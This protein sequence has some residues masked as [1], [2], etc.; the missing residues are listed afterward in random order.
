MLLGEC[1]RKALH[2][3]HFPHPRHDRALN[4]LQPLVSLPTL[5]N[6]R[7]IKHEIERE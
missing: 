5:S 4:R 3:V 6:Y 1:A 7:I 2:V